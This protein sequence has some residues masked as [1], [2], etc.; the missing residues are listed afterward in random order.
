MHHLLQVGPAVRSDEVVQSIVHSSPEN[1]QGCLCLWSL[2]FHG[3]NKPCL[4]NKPPTSCLQPQLL[5]WPSA[6]LTPTLAM[7]SVYCACVCARRADFNMLMWSN[8]QCWAEGKNSRSPGSAPR[9]A[10][11]DA[12]CHFCCLRSMLAPARLITLEVPRAFPPE[13]LSSSSVCI[14]AKFIHFQLHNLSW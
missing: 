3:L 12:V 2:H 9:D 10:A 6:H 8:R 13:L 7:S 1:L 4:L 5:S 11:L 14:I